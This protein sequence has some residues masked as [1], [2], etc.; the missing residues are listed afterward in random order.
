MYDE[1]NF[2]IECPKCKF[3]SLINFQTK[4][5]N[6]TLEKYT[7]PDYIEG[8]DYRLLTNKAYCNKCNEQ[9]LVTIKIKDEVF[10]TIY[11]NNLQYKYIDETQC[12]QILKEKNIGCNKIERYINIISQLCYFIKNQ[13]PELEENIKQILDEINLEDQIVDETNEVFFP[14][15]YRLK[16]GIIN[17][18]ESLGWRH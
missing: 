10:N 16:K 14:L 9:F 11:I 1:F 18:S 17:N 13:H 8:Y 5:L 3:K 7:F 12:K 6:C 2:E 15:Y 4:D